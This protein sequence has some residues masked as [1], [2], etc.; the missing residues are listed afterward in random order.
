MS[1]ILLGVDLQNAFLHPKGSLYIN[2]NTDAMLDKAASFIYRYDGDVYLTKD[3]HNKESCEFE[4]FPE[5]CVSEWDQEFVEIIGEAVNRRKGLTITHKKY[6]FSD[7]DLVEVLGDKLCEENMSLDV[8]GACT[9][10]CVHDIISRIVLY[11]RE[12]HN[13]NPKITLHSTM[14]DDF[15]GEMAG[16]AVKRM[17]NLYGVKLK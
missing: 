10:I 12:A 3:T 13:T 7:T 14:I 6:S 4:Q 8:I 5:H 2:H 11:C 1:K 16:F 9:H 17:Q 15:D